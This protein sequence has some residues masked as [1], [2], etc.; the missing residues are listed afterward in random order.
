MPLGFWPRRTLATHIKMSEHDCAS[1]QHPCSN[2]GADARV[3]A[4]CAEGQGRAGG[5]G[6]VGDSKNA[7]RGYCLDIPRFEESLNN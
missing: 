4:T 7:V 1:V 5:E 3:P 6:N 2:R